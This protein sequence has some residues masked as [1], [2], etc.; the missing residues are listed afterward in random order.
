MKK[1]QAPLSRLF[2]C[3]PLFVFLPMGSAVAESYVAPMLSYVKADDDRI[4]EDDY[5]VQ[6]ALG[7]QLSQSWNLELNLN[8]DTL[9]FENSSDEY[10]QFGL[11]LD[12]LYF[13]N[14]GSGL[15]TYGLVGVGGLRTKIGDDA[16]N[17]L[18]ANVGLGVMQPIGDSLQLRGEVR[19][20]IDKDDRMQGESR[21]DD[22]LVN[23]GLMIP[24][25]E[26]SKPVAKSEPA[27][28]PTPAP[29]VIVDSDGDGVADDQD[30]C[31]DTMAGHAVT[32]DGCAMDSDQDG[33]ADA[34]DQCA[35]TPLG[36]EVDQQ[37]CEKDS[38][39]D[40]VV[41]ALDECQN[42]P[43][44]VTVNEKG[45][46]ADLDGDGVMDAVDQCPDSEAGAKVDDKGCKLAEV[47]VLKG[48]TF[49]T[50]SAQLTSDSSMELNK[51]AETMKKY[52]SL[53]IKVSG[54]TDN[55]GAES[56]NQQ[57][58]Q[59]RA[60]AVVTFLVNQ[61]ISAQRL[62]AEGYGSANPIA[63]NDT[64]EGRMKNRRVEL[65]ILKR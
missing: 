32:A 18:S 42:T 3:A 25:G 1:P 33:V 50:G 29:V 24:F 17:N 6:I 19:Y 21:F 53:V 26:K 22:W 9:D 45:C 48:V 46:V 23:L 15:S 44:G 30:R 37:G 40:G 14:R 36:R 5:G 41:D 8:T 39:N 52:P 12:G 63:D 47:I 49:K 61:G 43:S 59:K 57:L 11:Q 16:D 56:F 55:R 64:P 62:Q 4:A 51:V 7:K 20:R 60:Q 54:Y 35:D 13:F 31:P 2:V 58:S 10:K 38:D 28:E 34:M 65:Q 27:P